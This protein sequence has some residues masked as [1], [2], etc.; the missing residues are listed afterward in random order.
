MPV[1]TPCKIS[2]DSH[3][4]QI[5]QTIARVERTTMVSTI[6]QLKAI[7]DKSYMQK[8]QEGVDKVYVDC[9]TALGKEQ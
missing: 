6:Q 1:G 3:G 7:L 9:M 4:G 2:L 8:L 5:S